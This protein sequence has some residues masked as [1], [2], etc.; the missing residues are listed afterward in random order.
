MKNKS[1]FLI[2]VAALAIRF[3]NLNQSFW[4][5]EGISVQA[6]STLSF[7]SII[8][9]FAPGDF[10]PPLY[11]LVLKIFLSTLGSSEVI[12]RLPSILFGVLT[13][14]VIYHLAKTLYDRKTAQIAAIL[15]ATSPLHIYYSQEARMYSMAAFLACLSLYFFVKII[16]RDK[17]NYWA[18]FILSTVALLYTDYM[19]YLIIISYF[20]YLLI[21]SK[22]LKTTLKS[23]IPTVLIILTLLLPWIGTIMHQLSLGISLSSS[24]P[25]WHSAIGSSSVKDLAILFPKFI[26]GRIS[27]DNNFTYMAVFAPIALFMTLLILIS[28]LRMNTKRS[29]LWFYLLVP[30]LVSYALSFYIPVFSYFRLLFVLPAFYILTA[31]AINNLNWTKPTAVMLII[32]L[33]VNIT[34]LTIYFTN[35]KFQREDWQGATEFVKSAARGDTQV[36]F[37]ANYVIPSFDIYNK[38]V[39]NAK[40]VLN[41]FNPDPQKV[42]EN[43]ILASQNTKHIFLFNYLAPI[44]D[45]S[46]LVFK[47]LVDIGFVN[48]ST[49]DFRGVG[50]IYEFTK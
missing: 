20:L 14:F 46:G 32:F 12:A 25:T 28:T 43:V 11:Y 35:P 19:P 38:N 40:G 30:I 44:S 6:A 34:S 5:D 41:S 22:K 36:F 17:I 27:P 2:L 13:V 1:I 45:P 8:L 15:L 48:T 42:S 24:S 18:G 7:K 29:I 37:E 39:L 9:N 3:I 31:S 10:H 50:F 21:F 47:S 4:L 23:F 26:I 33:A 16:E 49:K